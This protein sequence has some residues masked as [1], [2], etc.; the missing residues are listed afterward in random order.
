MVSFVAAPL[1]GAQDVSADNA[2]ELEDAAVH[3]REAVYASLRDLEHDHETAKISDGDYQA[4]AANCATA[5]RYLA[6]TPAWRVRAVS[7]GS[8]R[9]G[10]VLGNGSVLHSRPRGRPLL[11]AVPRAH[12]DPKR[13]ARD[14]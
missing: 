5:P 4:C 14:G 10:R 9:S 3:E 13:R 6:Q 11:R 8:E 12:R 2:M 1:R 7:R